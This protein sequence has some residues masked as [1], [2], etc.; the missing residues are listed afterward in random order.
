[1]EYIIGGQ[2]DLVEEDNHTITVYD[3]K[4]GSADEKTIEH[5]IRQLLLYVSLV[6][7]KIRKD[8]GK[9]VLYYLDSN[10]RI[11]CS[12]INSS[13]IE[14]I[15]RV[16]DNNNSVMLENLN[17]LTVKEVV[18]NFDKSIVKIIG[19]RYNKNDLKP[20]PEKGFN[21]CIKYSCPMFSYCKSELLQPEKKKT[22]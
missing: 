21:P 18:D 3:F 13:N 8:V 5:Y 4:T 14:K 15:C 20:I 7:E 9:A 16:S 12:L 17:V 2:V 6:Q 22:E 10:E 19:C 1:M 11:E